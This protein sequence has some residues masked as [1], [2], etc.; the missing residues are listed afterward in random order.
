MTGEVSAAV[1]GCQSAACGP[2]RPRDTVCVVG[3]APLVRVADVT[4]PGL[5]GGTAQLR[6]VLA[7]PRG[8]GP[9]P[10]VVMVHEAFG[11]DEVMRR[12]VERMASAG[13]LVVLPDLFTAGRV[14]C[15]VSTVAALS[16]GR[17]RAWQ[18]LEAARRMLAARDD[19]TGH[20]GV[21]GFCLGG[22][23][24]LVA[25]ARGF[26]V[27]SVNHGRL[28]GDLDPVVREACPVVASYG[29]RD[30]PRGGA[31]RLRAALARHGVAHDVQEYPDAGH[32]FLHD[33]E[34][35]PRAL[36]P[37]LRWVVGAG[38]EPSSAADAWRR[39]EAFFAE[40][41]SSRT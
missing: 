22:G 24:A 10:G 12:Q 29:A 36:R 28:P 38:P 13:Y 9:W 31:E 16:R 19:C 25:A 1:S 14:R 2:G 30:R 18:D 26:D 21:L 15:L 40:H 8:E 11:V 33:A 4:V 17:G 39:I 3:R 37:L 20:V 27:S 35:G 34:V 23:F 32:G 7:V 5:P 6:A 41:L